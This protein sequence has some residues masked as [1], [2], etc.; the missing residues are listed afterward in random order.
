L[1]SSFLWSCAKSET[2]DSTEKRYVITSPELAETI[3]Y[4]DGTERI[5]GVTSECNEPSE[6][7][8]KTIVGNFGKID[9]KMKD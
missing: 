6:L 5:F 2:Q 1:I 9:I 3:A 4:L 7:Q 8:S